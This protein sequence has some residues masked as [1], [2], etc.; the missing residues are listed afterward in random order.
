M[1]IGTAAKAVVAFV[2]AGGGALLT[3]MADGGV[4]ATEWVVVV[5]AAVGAA[6]AVWATTNAPAEGA[7]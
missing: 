5:M 7:K 6:G 1:K 3:A 2:T 4:T